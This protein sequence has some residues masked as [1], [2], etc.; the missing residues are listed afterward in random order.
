MGNKIDKLEIKEWERYKNIMKMNA[1]KNYK[2]KMKKKGK[3][4]RNMK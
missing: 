2:M 3:M 1:K 4:K